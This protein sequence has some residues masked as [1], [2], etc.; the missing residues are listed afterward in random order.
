MAFDGV[1]EDVRLMKKEGE[2]PKKIHTNIYMMNRDGGNIKQLT[3][4]MYRDLRPTFSPDGDTVVFVSNR[5]GEIRIWKLELENETNIPEIILPDLYAYRPIFSPDGQWLYFFV[6]KSR[7]RHQICRLKIE[8]ENVQC[9]END[10]RGYT[11]GPFVAPDGQS[12]YVHSTRGG[13]NWKIWRIP[14]D[15]SEP[16]SMQP[17]FF[18]NTLHPSISTNGIMAFDSILKPEPLETLLRI[19]KTII[20]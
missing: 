3:F 18:S 19:K 14:L 4:G 1:T 9:L 13:G 20:P 2:P 8:N 7:E 11:H 10:S 6:H 12:V 16:L 17:V 5:S 15:G